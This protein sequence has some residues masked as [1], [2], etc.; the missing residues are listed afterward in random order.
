MITVGNPPLPT[1]N[2]QQGARKSIQ[3]GSACRVSTTP[4][5]LERLCLPTLL[6]HR[7]Y[8]LKSKIMIYKSTSFCKFFRSVTKNKT[9][10]YFYEVLSYSFVHCHSIFMLGNYLFLDKAPILHIQFCMILLAPIIPLHSERMFS[11]EDC[12]RTQILES[13]LTPPFFYIV[14]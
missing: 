11:L 8:I 4:G 5:S 12:Y 2:V 10:R 7:P 13:L 1:S 6:L 3:S 14:L 9:P